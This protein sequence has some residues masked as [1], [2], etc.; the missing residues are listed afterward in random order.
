M[1][2]VAEFTINHFG[3]P[4][5]LHRMV[6]AAIGCGCDYI[7]LQRKDVETFYSQDRLNSSY[8]S[9]FGTTYRDYRTALELP[10]DE[11]K[12]ISCP[13]FVTVQDTQS[14]REMLEFDLPMY[15]IASCNSSNKDLLLEASQTIPKDRT[16]VISVAGQNL[17]TIQKTIDFFP[18]HSLIINH[19][20][21]I[22][23]CP[24]EK[25]KLGNIP[26]LIKEFGSN[27]IKI[28][29]SGHEIGLEA[30]YAVMEMGIYYLERHF[31][32]N[33]SSFIHHT[34]CS[35]EPNEFAKIK[36]GGEHN[37]PKSAFASSF[38]TSELESRFL[39]QQVYGQ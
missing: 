15:K 30:T 38:K 36:N 19:C 3:H 9:P 27:R 24:S 4:T 31:C 13:W 26:I 8:N 2:I 29:Y 16:I 1:I 10:L 18:N 37:L 33:R 17:K 35:L 39:V 25:L 11:F 20:V 12:K 6:A 23:P 21:A 14:L 7:K 5:L 28:G 32:M 22:Y 34:S